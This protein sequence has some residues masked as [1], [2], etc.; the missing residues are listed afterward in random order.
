MVVGVL[1]LDIYIPQSQSLKAKRQVIK[2]LKDK[3]RRRFN[4]SICELDDHNLWQRATL[5]IAFLSTQAN[6]VYPILSRVESSLEEE[7]RIQI[8]RSTIELR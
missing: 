4:V 5:G 2:G 1:R 6:W 3:L 8:L 7:G